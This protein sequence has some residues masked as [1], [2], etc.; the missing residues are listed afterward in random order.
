MVVDIAALEQIAADAWP[1]AR[2]DRIGDWRLFASS[3]FSGRI[4]ACWP[5]GE[6]GLDLDDGI[7]AVEA[8]YADRDLPP[9]FKIVESA[10]PPGLADALR[11]RHYRARTETL[12]MIGPVGGAAGAGVALSG[13]LNGAFATVFAAAGS[14]DPGDTRERLEALARVPSPR[15][16]AALTIAGR[17]AAIGAVAVAGRRAGIFAMRTDPARRRQGLA[18]RVL[19]TLAAFAAE[20][21]AATAY[22][23]VEADNAPAIALYAGEGFVEAYRYRYW[24]PERGLRDAVLAET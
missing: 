20:T 13:D 3:G 16:F 21:G 14:G 7:D 24:A 11:R 15:A 1:A 9:L 12:M 23:Q 4:N 18:R 10:A 8:W 5:L 19:Q 2:A 17:P 6:S 22:L